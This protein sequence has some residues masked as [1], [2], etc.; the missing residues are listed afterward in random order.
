[1]LMTQRQALE[2]L[3]PLRGQRIVVTT[4]SSAGLWPQL[5]DELQGFEA[6]VRDRDLQS[7]VLQRGLR[8]LGEVRIVLHQQ[9]Q[10]LLSG[11]GLHDAERRMHGGGPGA[12]FLDELVWL[13]TTYACPAARPFHDAARCRTRGVLSRG[14]CRTSTHSP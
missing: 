6:V 5:V 10:Q 11:S 8:D 12:K 7:F 4:M 1:M 9:D 14:G 2:V 13:S 3:L